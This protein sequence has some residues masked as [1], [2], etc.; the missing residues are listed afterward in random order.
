MMT[1]FPLP[2]AVHQGSD[3]R[4][5]K[6]VHILH[7]VDKTFDSH[8]TTLVELK[9]RP[10][11]IVFFS[12]DVNVNNFCLHIYSTYLQLFKDKCR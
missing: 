5:V 8:N 1:R 2:N 11:L 3:C 7:P 9:E 10:I 12:H 4:G 6:G